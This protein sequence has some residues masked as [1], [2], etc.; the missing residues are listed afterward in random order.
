MNVKNGIETFELTMTFMGNKAPI[1]P[2]IIWDN[3]NVILVDTGNPGQLE[4]IRIAMEKAGVAF[5]KLNKVIIT[6]QDNDHIGSLP[7]VLRASDH[8]IEVFAHE[9]DKEYIEGAKP[10]LKIDMIKKMLKSV[11]EEQ[12]K[13]EEAMYNIPIK[14]KVDKTVNDGE[15]LP[16][17]GGITVIYTPGH[18]PGHICLYLNQSKTL[19]AGDALNVIDGR[20]V[21]P[22]RGFATDIDMANKS[23]HKLSQF[24]VETVICYHGGVYEDNVNQRINEIAKEREQKRKTPAN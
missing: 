6:H 19:I 10:W 5:G 1:Y 22:I 11:P 9:A 18:T 8:K 24:D 12:R 17:C 16:F 23:L 15:V 2:T 3:D 7:E 20:L 4:G 13:A 21:G 14:A